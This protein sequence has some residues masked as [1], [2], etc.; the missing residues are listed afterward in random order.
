[1]TPILAGIWGGKRANAHAAISSQSTWNAGTCTHAN[2]QRCAGDKCASEIGCNNNGAMGCV[3]S[4]WCA[5]PR[6]VD[7]NH[8]PDTVDRNQARL[9]ISAGDWF[10]SDPQVLLCCPCVSSVVDRNLW[11]HAATTAQGWVWSW[12]DPLGMRGVRPAVWATASPGG[13]RR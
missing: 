3:R 6:A 8:R 5:P 12:V 2:S 11:E 4:L 9:E 13:T 10:D 7:R 1:M